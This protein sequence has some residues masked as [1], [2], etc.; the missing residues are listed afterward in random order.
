MLYIY[1]DKTQDEIRKARNLVRTYEAAV[2][3]VRKN[4]LS[5]MAHGENLLI[6]QVSGSRIACDVFGKATSSGG[7]KS[8]F[9]FLNYSPL[10]D[11]LSLD[12]FRSG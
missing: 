11:D 2:S 8:V 9:A 12:S 3:I 6:Y 7:Y 5:P 1:R 10:W 4:Y